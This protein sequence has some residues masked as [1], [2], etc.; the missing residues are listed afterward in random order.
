MQNLESATRSRRLT[1]LLFAGCVLLAGFVLTSGTAG[2]K[3]ASAAASAQQV[4]RDPASPQER[5]AHLWVMDAD[6]GNL[7]LLSDFPPIYADYGPAWSPDG[8]HIAFLSA[9]AAL[10]LLKVVTGAERQ[11]P[12]KTDRP[13]F[14]WR[15]SWSPDG[16]RL[17]VAVGQTDEESMDVDLAVI[18]VASGALAVLPLPSDGATL[19]WPGAWS[20]DGEWIAF[21]SARSGDTSFEIYIAPA[22]GGEPVELTDG[23][24]DELF[25]TWSPGGDQLAFISR[26]DID[27]LDGEI[28]V[29]EA[30]GANWTQITSR[31]TQAQQVAWS[32]AGERLV[33]TVA[34]GDETELFNETDTEIHTIA[35]DGSGERNLTNHP[36][37]DA[38]PTWSPDGQRIAFVS[39]RDE[40]ELPPCGE[41]LTIDEAAIVQMQAGDCVADEPV[42]LMA[43]WTFD[44]QGHTIW[45]VDPADGQRLAGGC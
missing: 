28:V 27:T 6:G 19:E 13:V 38:I 7:Q 40:A 26:P 15:P 36:A 35:S 17:L 33:F 41:R 25:P 31:E 9:P 5:E 18:D 30:D 43:G 2:V 10:T 3:L 23:P 37:R 39:D 44:G 24:A 14:G 45:A 4:V 21:A 16:T 42:T 32:P 1:S 22:A 8:T 12:I 34:T 20:P 29:I 11:L